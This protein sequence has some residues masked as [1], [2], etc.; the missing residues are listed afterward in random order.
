VVEHGCGTAVESLLENEDN[1]LR[2]E[3]SGREDTTVE[4]LD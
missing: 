1:R 3:T 2:L 4:P